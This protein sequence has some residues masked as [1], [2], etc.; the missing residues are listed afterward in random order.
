MCLR[1]L[2]VAPMAECACAA[3]A[4]AE[5]P[6]E[7]PR[8]PPLPGVLAGSAQPPPPAPLLFDARHSYYYYYW[9]T[10]LLFVT[11]AMLLLGLVVFLAL[12]VV[13]E[14]DGFVVVG[15]ARELSRALDSFSALMVFGL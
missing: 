5:P 8:T 13:V 3:V 6:R 12:P 2:T 9:V 15:A 7:A 4:A 1:P 14:V 10:L 11:A